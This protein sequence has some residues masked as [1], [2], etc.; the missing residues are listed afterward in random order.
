MPRRALAE[1]LPSQLRGAASVAPGDGFVQAFARGLRVIQAF[2][3]RS[4]QLTLTEV[5][6]AAQIT[7]AGARRILLTLA[8]LGYVKLDGRAFSLTPRILSLGFPYLT[9]L[10]FWNLAE[11]VMEALVQELHESCSAAVLDRDEIVYVVRVPTQKIMTINLSVGSRLPAYCTSMGRVL[12]AGLD[13]QE[14]TEILRESKLRALT[15][16]TETRIRRLSAI[17]QDARGKGWAL[18]DQELEE[19]LISL[20]VPIVGS[21]GRTIAAMN[22]SGQ[23]N[24][25]P[26]AE[27]RRRFLAPLQNAARRISS[28]MVAQGKA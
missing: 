26:A 10:P 20:A 2:D 14:A 7:R 18:V 11:P 8:R 27:M 22:I 15:P 12:L 13:P 9:S 21:S 16:R 25:T 19:G 23:A 6:E 17:V 4:R 24:R 1:A 28:V 5:A 3:G